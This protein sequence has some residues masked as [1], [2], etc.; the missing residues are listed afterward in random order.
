MSSIC[1]RGERKTHSIQKTIPFIGEKGEGKGCFLYQ[2][3]LCQE[4]FCYIL[5][6]GSSSSLYKLESPNPHGAQT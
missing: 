2:K 6:G 5:R 1:E 4:H 3:E